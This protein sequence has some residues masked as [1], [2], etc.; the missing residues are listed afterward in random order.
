MPAPVPTALLDA[1]I[2]LRYL[3]GDPEDLADRARLLFERAERGEVHLILTPL[4][5]AE[6]V[7]VFKSFYKH[8]L[9]AIAGALQQVMALEGVSTEQEG[10]VGA[11]LL[12]MARHN[13]DFVDAYLAELARRDGLSVATFD[14]DFGRLGVALLAT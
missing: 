6:C 10:V 12:G 4:T 14:R 8:P 2:L 5:V 7:W 9:P 3:S 11:A 1:N 13:V